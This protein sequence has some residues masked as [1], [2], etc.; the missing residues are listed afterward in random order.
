[1]RK[2]LSAGKE[3]A[4]LLAALEPFGGGKFV[5]YADIHQKEAPAETGALCIV[6]GQPRNRDFIFLNRVRWIPSVYDDP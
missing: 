1:M 6:F 5:S 3:L 2:L 4:D